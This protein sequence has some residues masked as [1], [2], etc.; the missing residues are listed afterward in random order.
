HLEGT[1]HPTHEDAKND[2]NEH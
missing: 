2:P 1:V